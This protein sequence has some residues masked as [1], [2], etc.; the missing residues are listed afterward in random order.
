MPEIRRVSFMGVPFDI[1]PEESFDT[2]F[3]RAFGSGRG[4]TIVLLRYR[5]FRK[6]CWRADLRDK[7]HSSALVLPIDKSLE[8]GMRFLGLPTPV[9]YHP[10]DFMIKLLGSMERKNR[11]IYLLGGSPREVQSVFDKVRSGFPRITV[12]GRHAGKF[13]KDSEEAVLTAI[14]K[15]SPQLLFLGSRLTGVFKNPFD[16]A[17]TLTVPLIVK[18]GE[19][20]DIMSGRKRIPQREKFKNQFRRGTYYLKG[21]FWNPLRWFRLLSYVLYGLHLLWCRIFHRSR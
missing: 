6:A 1:L 15:A 19:A 10:F 11:S 17:K 8:R 9:R 7:L 13:P 20:F 16:L 21:L 2:F 5:D 4:M 18:L 3:E 12:I 14:H